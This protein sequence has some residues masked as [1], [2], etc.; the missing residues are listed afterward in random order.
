GRGGN[1]GRGGGGGNQPNPG[2]I[3]ANALQNA[4]QAAGG[5]SSQSGDIRIIPE[6][7]SNSL[8]IRAT[9]SDWALVQAVIQGVD[10]R[11]LQVRV[12]VTIA[13]V[14][15]TDDPNISGTRVG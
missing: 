1:A 8:L 5:L 14:Q 13:A 3:I 6:E 9:E 10:L 4:L 11:P 7:T 2:G 12:E 15:P